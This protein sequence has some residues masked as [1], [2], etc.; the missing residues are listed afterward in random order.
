MTA[1]LR[2]SARILL[3]AL[4]AWAALA[5][6]ATAQQATTESFDPLHTRFGFELRTRWGQR[7]AGDFPDYAGELTVL[8]DGRH[9]VRIV[10][11]TAAVQVADSA[12]YT[13][14]ARGP[15]FFDSARYPRIEFLSEPHHADV[16]DR[17]GRLRG[18]LSM[19][20]VS[21]METFVLAPA[22][23]ARPGKDCDVLATGSISR[24]DYGLDGWQLALIDRVRFTLRV[25]L[26]EPAR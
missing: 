6:P 23:C 18:K 8:P 2:R 15:R 19:H 7:V 26:L 1:S 20:G 9:Q 10:L 25:R 13:E 14:L 22:A 4:L 12:R 5:A 21:R 16:V 24:G 3:C 17:G 11:A